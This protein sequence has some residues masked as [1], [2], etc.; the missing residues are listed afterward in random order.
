MTI[1]VIG[2]RTEP[3]MSM[4]MMRL[5]VMLDGYLNSRI[6]DLRRLGFAL[7]VYDVDDPDRHYYAS[8][9]RPK[10]ARNLLQHLIERI[11]E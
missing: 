1:E 7:V 3:E 11:P 2:P 6:G 4:M 10:L 9:A 8:S 5:Q